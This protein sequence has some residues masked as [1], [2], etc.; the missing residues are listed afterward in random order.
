M[1]IELYGDNTQDQ[2]N[3][4]AR[5]YLKLRHFRSGSYFRDGTGNIK[6]LRQPLATWRKFE[7]NRFAITDI[8]KC[9]EKKMKRNSK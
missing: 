5:V 4:P 2:N 7:F 9:N 1:Y 8:A 3:M 6:Q